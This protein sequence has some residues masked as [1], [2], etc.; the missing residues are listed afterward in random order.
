MSIKNP[1][2]PENPI[3]WTNEQICSKFKAAKGRKDQ[4]VTH[5]REAF[6]YVTPNRETFYEHHPGDKKTRLQFDNTAMEAIQVFGSRIMATITPSWQVW[7]EFRAGSDIPEEEQEDINK[8]LSEQN[9]ILFDFINHSNFTTQASETYL[10]IG[11]GTG[12]MVIEEGDLDDLLVFT[13]IPLSQLYLEEG[14]D[15]SIRSSWRLMTPMASNLGTMFPKGN[16]SQATN[17]LIEKDSD[18]RV[19]VITGSMFDPKSKLYYQIVFELGEKHLVQVHTEETNPYII[20]RWSVIPGEIYGRGPALDMLPTIKT[21]NKMTEFSLRHAAMAVSGAYTA[22]SD[23]VI[24]PYN[25]Q[26]KPNTVIPVKA[27]DSLQPVPMAGSPD[28][29]NFVRSELREDIQKAFFA[30]PMPSFNDPVRTATEMSIRNSEML[31]NSGAQLGRLKSEW[32]EPIIARCVAILKARGKLADITIDGREVTIKHTSPLAKIED[33]EDLMGFNDF[34]T[35]MERLEP[36][37]PGLLATTVKLEE[38]P[39]YLAGRYGG[40]EQL[41]RTTQEA[42]ELSEKVIAAGEAQLEE[43]VVDG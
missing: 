9:S 6:Q 11:Y 41:I 13:N 4:W 30:N 27:P 19:E 32:I 37:S 23:G 18:S 39:S 7:S 16:F 5:Y 1:Q 12:G 2:K 34:L 20:P 36:H 21:L 3:P 29:S 40:F 10:D 8:Q 43:G 14:P 42:E 33:Q 24:N 35:T 17:K 22:V 25:I 28:F 26:I 15:S 38:V 31:K